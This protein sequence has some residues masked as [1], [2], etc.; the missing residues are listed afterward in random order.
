MDGIGILIDS[1]DKT[2]EFAHYKAFLRADGKYT[3]ISEKGF[4]TIGE[5]KDGKH[6]GK[7]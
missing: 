5:W 7:N 3:R 4:F 6:Y 2:V 1:T